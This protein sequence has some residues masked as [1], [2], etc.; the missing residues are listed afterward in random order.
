MAV[1]V[2][3]NGGNPVNISS[4]SLTEDSTPIDPNDSSGGIGQVNVSLA[5]GVDSELYI[6]DSVSIVDSV[7]GSFKGTINSVQIQQNTT[8]VSGDSLVQKLIATVDA[9]MFNGTLTNAFIYYLSLANITSASDYSIDTSFNSVNV[10]FQGFSGELWTYMKEI[11]AVYNAEMSL[12]SN[13]IT[14]R[15]IRQKTIISNK[16]S[17]KSMS[18]K[19]NRLAQSVDVYY[20]N[21]KYVNNCQVYPYNISYVTGV[22]PGAVWVFVPG[23]GYVQ[24]PNAYRTYDKNAQ[25]MS[26][27]ANGYAEYTVDLNASISGLPSTPYY[28]GDSPTPAGG[29]V[30][31][32]NPQLIG[33][34]ILL[35]PTS[36]DYTWSLFAG[37]AK[38]SYYSVCGKNG[39][40]ISREQ[41]ISQGGKVQAY[42]TNNGNSILFK[43]YGM[44]DPTNI[45]PFRLGF[46]AGD[47]NIYPYMKV[48]ATSAVQYDKQ[49]VN[50]PTGVPASKSVQAVGATVDNIFISTLDQAYRLGSITAGSFCAPSQN[51]SVSASSVTDST[52]L[53]GGGPIIGNVAGARIQDGNSMYRIRS[54]TLTQGDISYEAESDSIFSDFDTLWGTSR[55]FAD[56]DTKFS[57]KN[58]EDF[59]IR[60][61]ITPPGITAPS[62]NSLIPNGDFESGT[63]PTGWSF[64]S[65]LS[66]ITT[67]YGSTAPSPTHTLGISYDS[68]TDTANGSYTN[69]SLL[70]IGQA[71]SISFYVKTYTNG[72]ILDYTLNFGTTTFTSSQSI[73]TAWAKITV[74]NKVCAGNTTFTLSVSERNANEFYIDNVALIAGTVAP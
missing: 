72:L 10:S 54:A 33:N 16:N 30:G 58:F 1:N 6:N 28:A 67:N 42:V 45:G 2:S 36:S 26:V 52:N 27:D 38:I 15:P 69:S 25:M 48:K 35:E 63:L 17:T 5:S 61:L 62:F 64:S 55:T 73:G 53:I 9:G 14:F 11:C 12:V 29:A 66:G 34:G 50:I 39:V 57:G 13:K 4:Y 20:Y 23:Q 51:I 44:N 65:T 56:F 46:T 40:E 41:W 59:G 18:V 7:K 22:E 32:Y 43:L 19:N 37:D 31:G 68:N 8:T 49:K 47:N 71:Y 3:I 74:N 21:N 24:Q 60:P 70:T